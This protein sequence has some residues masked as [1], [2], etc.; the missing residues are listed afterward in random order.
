MLGAPHGGNGG[1]SAAGKA[2]KILNSHG[3]LLLFGIFLAAA[4]SP[5]HGALTVKS[6]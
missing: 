2:L 4:S 6:R 5:R 3:C 1:L